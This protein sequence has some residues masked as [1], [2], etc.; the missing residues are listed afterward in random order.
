VLISHSQGPRQHGDIRQAGIE[1]EDGHREAASTPVNAPA[2]ALSDPVGSSA[3]RAKVNELKKEKGDDDDDEDDDEKKRKNSTSKNDHGAA[4]AKK[5]KKDDEDDEDDVDGEN[6]GVADGK[7]N[8]NSAKD[9]GRKDSK[10]TSTGGKSRKTSTVAT[11][12]AS[13]VANADLEE[14]QTPTE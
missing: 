2:S 5:K 3:L 10:A 4:K 1:H 8:N 14:R 9:K 6:D 13:N 7:E 11:N 12:T